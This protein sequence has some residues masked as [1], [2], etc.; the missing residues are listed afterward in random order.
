[1]ALQQGIFNKIREEN[2]EQEDIEDLE[3]SFAWMD[4]EETAPVQEVPAAPAPVA[5]GT[6]E[7]CG[8]GEGKGKDGKKPAAMDASSS[9]VTTAAMSS[10][11]GS[12][13]FSLDWS[14]NSQHSRLSCGRNTA[15]IAEQ[16]LWRLPAPWTLEYAVVG[17]F[18]WR[19]PKLLLPQACCSCCPFM[20]NQ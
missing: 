13:R 6:P 16:A 12:S 1:M 11:N 15:P 2:E 14:A 18:Q 9:T 19:I 5:A 8:A 4:L 20:T 17:V 7:T 3:G 10:F